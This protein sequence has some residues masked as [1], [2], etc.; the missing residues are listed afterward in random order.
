MA[1]GFNLEEDDDSLL[2][3][4]DVL[5]SHPYDNFTE[6]EFNAISPSAAVKWNKWNHR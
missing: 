3:D 4:D 2:M 6:E 1:N 5:Y